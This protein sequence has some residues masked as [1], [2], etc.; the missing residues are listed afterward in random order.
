MTPSTYDGVLDLLKKGAVLE[1]QEQ[2]NAMHAR[3]LSCRRGSAQHQ[4]CIHAT[5]AE[6]ASGS[7]LESD[8][9]ACYL[10]ENG[11]KNGPFCRHCYDTAAKLVRLQALDGATY[12]CLDCKQE[13]VRNLCG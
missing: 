12:V 9:K 11:K 1:A 7:R 13:S 8:G 3:A 4:D 5:Q 6:L 10:V 2:F